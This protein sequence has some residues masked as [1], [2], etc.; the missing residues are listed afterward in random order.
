M[1]FEID[2]SSDGSDKHV[3]GPDFP[4]ERFHS[5]QRKSNSLDGPTKLCVS[6][7]HNKMPDRVK[8][9]GQGSSAAKIQEILD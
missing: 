9:S 6:E 1:K 4:L 3:A 7:L 2:G 5:T 8:D